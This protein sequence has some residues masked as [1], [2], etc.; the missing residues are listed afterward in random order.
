MLL[1]E[2]AIEATCRGETTLIRQYGCFPWWK[3]TSLLGFNRWHQILG[4]SSLNWLLSTWLSLG[5]CPGTL[6]EGKIIRKKCLLGL[7]SAGSLP[8]GENHRASHKP[9]SG[10]KHYLSSCLHKP[11]TVFMPPEKCTL[12]VPGCFPLL[13]GKPLVVLQGMSSDPT[14]VSPKEFSKGSAHLLRVLLLPWDLRH[15]IPGLLII[16]VVWG[17]E[18]KAAL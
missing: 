7:R 10:Q 13:Q 16:Q 5:Q 9:L 18:S 3:I 4:S 17:G 2:T 12:R 8:D 15:L 6:S 11:Y 14:V 1:W